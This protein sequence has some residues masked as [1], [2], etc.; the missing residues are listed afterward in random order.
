MP[1]PEEISKLVQRYKNNRDQYR[2]SGYKETE[3]RREFLDPL[4]KALG[5]D[6]DNT[7]DFAEQYKE[8]VHE[9]SLDV[10]GDTRA[11]ETETRIQRQIEATDREIDGLVYE[12]YGLTGD[13]VMIVGGE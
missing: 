7:Q 4:F 2:S 8:V 12:L 3:L 13:E 9:K 11:P 6:V 1:A 10:E 5:W